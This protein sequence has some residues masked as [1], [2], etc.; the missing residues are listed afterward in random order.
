MRS[1]IVSGALSLLAVVQLHA[2]VFNVRDFGAVADDKTDNTGA[3][4]KCLN[5]IVAAGGGQMVLPAGVYRGRIEIPPVSKSIPSWIT[6]EIVGEGE[7]APV[8]G[9]IVKCLAESGGA[10]I[11]VPKPTREQ[12]LYLGFSAVWAQLISSSAMAAQ[13]FRPGGSVPS[14]RLTNNKRQ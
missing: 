14:Q 1:T 12:A 5:A 4:S 6:V 10:V 11:S 2:A 3:F 13:R 7:P 9:S 8:F